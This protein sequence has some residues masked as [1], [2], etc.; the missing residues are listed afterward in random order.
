M[1]DRRSHI[2]VITDHQKRK[3]LPNYLGSREE[4]RGSGWG[5]ARA[6]RAPVMTAA[7]IGIFRCYSL[8]E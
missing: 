5:S 6:V 8:N 7:V 2:W 3:R 1:D 4:R